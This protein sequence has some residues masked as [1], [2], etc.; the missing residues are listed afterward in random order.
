[1]QSP[2]ERESIALRTIFDLREGHD[3]QYPARPR[4]CEANLTGVGQILVCVCLRLKS[5]TRD[6]SK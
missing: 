5:N 6:P 2:C 3:G 4:K 1:M